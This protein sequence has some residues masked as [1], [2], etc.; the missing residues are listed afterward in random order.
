MVIVEI[1]PVVGGVERGVG[2]GLAKGRRAGDFSILLTKKEPSLNKFHISSG[3]HACVSCGR[4]R[5]PCS[6]PPGLH[7]TDLVDVWWQDELLH[8]VRC[9]ELGAK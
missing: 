3:E 5:L 9:D 2:E 7:P 8:G 6:A 4:E 1:W